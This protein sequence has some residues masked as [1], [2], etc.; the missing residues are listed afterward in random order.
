MKFIF[1]ILTISLFFSNLGMAQYIH[2]IHDYQPA[3]GQFINKEPFGTPQAAQS[4]VG[5]INGALSLGAFG[6]YVVFSFES[7]VKNNPDNPYGVDFIIFGNPLPAFC[8]PGIVSVMK[9]ENGNGL[10]DD[11][12][13]ELAGSDYFFRGTL[14]RNEMTYFNPGSPQ[15]V[16]VPW[17]DNFAH[18]GVVLAKSFH[19]QPY[20]PDITL[21]PS[22]GSV[23][24]KYTGTRIKGKIDTSNPSII[25]SARRTFGYADNRPRGT[26]PF[27]K[28][29]NP[30]IASVENAGGDGF[31]I[32]WAVDEEGNYV[33]LNEIHF[34]KVHTGMQADAG[35]LGEIS[36]EITGAVMAEPNSTL[37]G[38]SE[39]IVIRDL[40]AVISILPFQLEAFAF[41]MGRIQR[42]K[43]ILWASNPEGAFVDDKM[44]LHAAT[45][46]QITLTATLADNPQISATISVKIDLSNNL[47]S[48]DGK[49]RHLSVYPN[50]ASEFIYIDGVENGSIFIYNP[51][52]R[53]IVHQEIYSE[54]ERIAV[55][56]LPKGVY[57]L[58][59][60]SGTKTHTL[61]FVKK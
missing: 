16:N 40:P 7:P 39:M 29:G 57:F 17:A 43:K 33:D 10:P 11:N 23:S 50:P 38:L 31:D 12:W 15:A 13:Y 27:T 34:I 22:V 59:V 49:N 1:S 18:S 52:G 37:K 48:Y 47:P 46:G 32:G 8:E 2:K 14:Q 6:G 60:I 19:T 26:A 9:D 61:R 45:P 44:V 55:S 30:Y 21:F 36:T 41:N 24:H 58:K 5:T 51:E 3:P 4:I 35:W 25:V 56:E 42:D 28:P 54:G 20:Y 53:L